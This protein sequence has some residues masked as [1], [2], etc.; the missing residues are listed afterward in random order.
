MLATKKQIRD[1]VLSTTKQLQSQIGDLV[2]TYI[3]VTM[4]EIGDPAWAF[5]KERHH[6]WSWLKRKTTFSATSED[7]VLERDVDRIAIMRQLDS[8]TKIEFVPD[9]V[10][11]RNIPDPDASGNPY[12]YRL[13]EVI[14]TSARL[15]TASALSVS[16]SSSSDDAEYSVVVS[17]YIS[18]RMESETITMNGTSTV[19]GS[20]TFD[21]RE[22]FISKSALFNGNLTVKDASA[23]TLV[24]IGPE[25]V[26]PRFKVVSLYPIPTSSTIYLEYYKKVKELN[27]DHEMP[28]FDP[29][30]HYTVLLGTI[31]KVYQYLG[32]SAD[33][34]VAQEVYSKAVRAMAA[35]DSAQTDLIMH[36]RRRDT[37]GSI[38]IR[39]SEEISV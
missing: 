20:K 19:S 3:N 38:G 10:F 35:S 2:D 28:E 36:M 25:E 23:N 8:P 22:L 26:S 21:A 4:Q 7:T 17:G 39:S 31:A 18:G 14:G 27:N 33:Y 24:I 30:W 15:G 12:M 13:W 37:K 6:S 16:S 11:Y 32:K 9:D 1:S 34:A 5:P 29:K